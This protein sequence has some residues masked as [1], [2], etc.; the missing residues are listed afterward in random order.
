[1]KI[2][3]RF[4]PLALL[5]AALLTPSAAHADE[6][7]TPSS[8]AM[9]PA[10]AAATHVSESEKTGFRARLLAGPT[11]R[12]IYSVP[13]IAADIQLAVGGQWKGAAAYFTVNALT[14]GTSFGLFTQH[15][16]PGVMVEGV[17]DRLRLGGGLQLSLTRITRETNGNAMISL[18]IGGHLVAS[19]DI[20]DFDGGTFLAGA[21]LSVDKLSGDGGAAGPVMWGPTAFIGVRF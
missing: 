14:G 12:L 3:L 18:G 20:V 1:M 17:L 19:Y 16:A 9:A 21:R 7:T 10:P 13:V 8:T 2:A 11:Y 6:S 4:A 5:L 15:Y